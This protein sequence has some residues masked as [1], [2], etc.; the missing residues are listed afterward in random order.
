MDKK[1]KWV[2]GIRIYCETLLEVNKQILKLVAMDCID[3]NG[4]MEKIFIDI[5]QNIIRL[6][7]CNIP[8]NTHDV[9]LNINE[10]IL[11]FIFELEFLKS[12]YEIMFSNNKETLYKI[13]FIRNKTEHIPH[14]LRA[15]SSGS[16]NT[17]FSDIK[18]E[19][20]EEKVKIDSKSIIKIVIELNSIFKKIIS[21]LN[22]YRYSLDEKHHDHPYFKKYGEL[23]FE[24]FNVILN[25]DSLYDI[26]KI[27]QEF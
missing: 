7:P 21:R 4:N 11:D 27:I 1:D 15:R 25:S 3:S 19:F 9:V 5:S 14:M 23:N 24:R 8:R 16:G 22:T 12:D 18:F 2:D 17:S 13:K 10:G 26:S 20:E 6:V